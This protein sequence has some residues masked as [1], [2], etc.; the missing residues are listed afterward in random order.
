MPNLSSVKGVMNIEVFL[1]EKINQKG[2]YC[3]ILI[4][5][6]K[7]FFPIAKNIMDF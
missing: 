2:N 6:K 7:Y 5:L 4:F 3:P 1:A